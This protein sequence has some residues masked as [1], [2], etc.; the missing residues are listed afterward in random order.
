MNYK[1]F[2]EFRKR[3]KKKWFEHAKNFWW[4]DRL[5][6][7]FIA[8]WY[9]KTLKNKRILDVGCG[10]GIVLSELEGSNQKYG[11]DISSTRVSLAK[12]I[13][14]DNAN[15]QKADM[16]N[17]PFDKDSF[18]VVIF[19]GMF[20]EVEDNEERV[21]CLKEMER[22]LKEDGELII[23][24]ANKD[25]LCWGEK[26][27]RVSYCI[28]DSLLKDRFNKVIYGFNPLPEFP[29]FLPNRV[30]ERIPWIWNILIYLMK[31]RFMYKYCRSF[32]VL[33]GK[34]FTCDGMQDFMKNKI[35]ALF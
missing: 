11:V 3:I 15:V 26:G 8:L 18:D 35:D 4:G 24:V 14:G 5:D 28:L 12:N 32:L 21:R 30:I 22:V 2:N 34:K 9:L 33:A 31:K 20:T 19:F 27:S 13:L 25:Y 6:S 16:F 1:E 10:A 23:T 29:L 7:R 17:L